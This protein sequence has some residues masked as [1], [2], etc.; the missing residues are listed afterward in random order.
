MNSATDG[1]NLANRLNPLLPPV[2]VTVADVPPGPPRGRLAGPLLVVALVGLGIGLRAVPLVQNRNL[3]IDEAML[4]L[5]LVE[6]SPGRLLEPLGW[7]QGAPA[8][9]LLASKLAIDAL[10][11]TEFG[12][13]LVPF[14]GSVFGLIAFA[15]LAPRLLPRPAAL[16]GLA[17]FAASPYLVSYAVEC[18]QYSTD[19]AVT[20]GLFAVAAGLLRGERGGWRWAALGLAGALAVWFSHPAAFVLGG[21][22][23]ALLAEAALGR[24]RKRFLAA[25]A[26]VGCWLVSFAVCYVLLLRQ[27]GSNQYLLDYWA[28]HF[29][30]LPPKEVG[31]TAWLL[32]HFFGFFQFPGGLGGTEIKAGG[33]AAVLFLVGVYG[34]WKERW[35]VAVALVLPAVF[36]LLASGLHKYPFSGRLLLFLV[37]LMLLGV[38]RGA[39][40]IGAALWSSQPVAAVV[41]FGVLTAAPVLETWQEFRRPM[42]YEQLTP[43]I[44]QVRQR[45]QPGDRMYVYYG[46]VPAFTFYTRDN[47]PFPPDAVT[48]GT[49][50][51]DSRTSYRDEL[52]GLKGQRRVWVVFSHRHKDEESFVRAYAEGMGRCEEVVKEPGAAAY[53]FD[54]SATTEPPRGFP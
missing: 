43:V 45:W 25:A 6:R 44:A 33:I 28:G 37:P 11:P 32:D 52:A 42:R 47:P 48:L 8:G 17:L 34:F 53:L 31:D 23:T 49:E 27:L 21:I 26:T 9:F 7:N 12:L 50:F 18:K 35:P 15:W 29:L 46:A 22:G 41:L 1:P 16:F 10:G 24:D 54:F 13:R 14:L 30:P 39:G 51:R 4:A 19:A 38:A 36:A 3:W 20:A 40:M 5:N 2:I